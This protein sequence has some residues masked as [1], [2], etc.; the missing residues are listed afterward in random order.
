MIIIKIFC[1]KIKIHNNNRIQIKK[2]LKININQIMIVILNK[3]LM[4]SSLILKTK[5]NTLNNIYHKIHKNFFVSHP[6]KNNRNSCNNSKFIKGSSS[7]I[8]IEIH[9]N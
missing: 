6:R 5:E 8:K 3:I 4:I 2:C 7:K 1:F 9:Y